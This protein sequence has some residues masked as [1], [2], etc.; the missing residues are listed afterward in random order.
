MTGHTFQIGRML[1]ASLI[2]GAVL[3]GCGIPERV[4]EG[5]RLDLRATILSDGEDAAAV[6][7]A[8]V[9]IDKLALASPATNADWTHRNGS[10]QHLI[11]HPALGQS[12]TKVWSANIGSGNSNKHSITASPLVVGGRVYTMDAN[13]GVRAF[14]TAGAP[15]WSVDLTPPNEKANEASGGGMAF[16]GGVLA[17]TTGHGEVVVLDPASGAVRW[18]HQMSGA[19]SAD[20]VIVGSTVVAVAR[21]N[22]ALGLDIKNGRIQWQQLSPGN[23]TGIA[24]SGAPAALGKLVVIPFSSGELVGTVATNGLRAWSGSVSGG[25]KGLARNLVADISSDPV[26]DGRTVYVANQTGRLAAMDRRSGSRLWT[27]KDG[28][29]TPVWPAGGAVFMVTDRFAVKRLNA[30]DGTEVWSQ[31]LPDFK[32]EKDRRKRAT[33]AYF[34]PVLA[35]GQVWVAGSDGL[36]RSYNPVNG[37]LTGTIDI[38]GGAASQPAIAGGRMY[39]MS[40]NGQIHAYQ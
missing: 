35:G 4:L 8:E 12:L 6:E 30:S 18:R 21:N 28:S 20:P 2:L 19:I 37:T 27:A 34:G 38:P 36:L 16:G 11:R 9:R 1:T 32:Q 23:T 29:Y 7:A 5:E 14:T 40:A 17:V 25:N 13:A 31:E 39:V 24:G 22:V 26:I 33:Y 3:V 15:V 10:A